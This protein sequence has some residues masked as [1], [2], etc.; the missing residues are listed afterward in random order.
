MGNDVAPVFGGNVTMPK[1]SELADA[2]NTSGDRNPRSGAS[3]DGKY[4]NFSGK[5]G[6]F[7]VGAGEDKDE[8]DIETLLLPNIAAFQNGWVCW[9]G[10]RPVDTRM[11]SIMDPPVVT[12][13]M[14]EHGPF[15]SK[16]GEG[17]YQ[18]KAMMLRDIDSEEQY[19][20][21]VN[22]V[23]GVDQIA[24]LEKAIADRAKRGEPAWPVFKFKIED[25]KAHGHTNY[26]PVIVV[27]GWLDDVN[28]QV[29]FSDPD[30]D[31][32]ELVAASD[33][34]ASSSLPSEGNGETDEEVVE[35]SSDEGASPAPSRS[36]RSRRRSL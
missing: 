17:W 15:D 1:A 2:L 13:D 6:R 32:D 12:P 24:K 5:S 35:P 7:S 36:R 3:G 8:Y 11:A 16:N 29:L 21:K 22:S 34:A 19:Y 9:K 25:F 4:L 20:F 33:I 18:A 23:S 28:V 14:N 27:E 26:K 30:A 31:L 10:G